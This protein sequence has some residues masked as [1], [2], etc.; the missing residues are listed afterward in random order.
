MI[1]ISLFINKS[2][3]ERKW[4]NAKLNDYAEILRAA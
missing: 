2:I 1:T 4:G 3:I